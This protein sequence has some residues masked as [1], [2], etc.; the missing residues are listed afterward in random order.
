MRTIKKKIWPEYF[1]EVAANRKHFEVRL[2][3]FKIQRGDNIILEEWNPKTKKYTGKKLR[4]KAGVVL[5][6]PYDM[7]RFYLR[8]NIKK[9]GFFIIELK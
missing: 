1:R 4:F 5:K 3:D 6:V 8:K 2:A 9:Y 7:E